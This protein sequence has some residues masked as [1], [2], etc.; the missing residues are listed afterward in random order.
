MDNVEP[1]LQEQQPG[2]EQP[3]AVAARGRNLLGMVGLLLSVVGVVATAILAQRVV[4]SVRVHID[5]AATVLLVLSGFG[6]IGLFLSAAGVFRRPKGLAFAGVVLGLVGSIAFAGVGSYLGADRLGLLPPPDDDLERQ[7]TDDVLRDAT[8]IIEGH[9]QRHRSLPTD[10]EA[11]ELLAGLRDGWGH[12]LLYLLLKDED[13]YELSS[14]GPDGEYGNQD[15][16]LNSVWG[17]SF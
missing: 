2:A 1:T 9:H 11:A 14:A 17:E 5:Q 8:A 6:V 10:A 4:S 12:K 7:A 13:A 3:P 16:I 15:D